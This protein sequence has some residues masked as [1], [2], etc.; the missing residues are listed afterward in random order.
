[1]KK[2]VFLFLLAISAIFNLTNGVYGVEIVYEIDDYEIIID[3]FTENG[4]TGFTVEKTGVNPFVSTVINGTEHYYITGVSKIEEYYIL[5]GYGFTSNSDTE[6]DSLFFILDNAGNVIKKDL[7]DYGF[8]EVIKEVYIIDNIFI[9]YTE[10]TKDIDYNYEFK[11]NYFTT[12]DLNFN[13][14]NS[15]EIGSKIKRIDSNDQ[16][17]LIGYDYYLDYDFAIRSDLTILECDTLLELN[18]GEV[19][20]DAVTIEF[21]NSATLNNSY[22]ENGVFI[23][24][25]GDY[26]LIYNDK[27]Y[28][29]VVE[30]TI[31]GVEDNFIYK[32]SVT[33]FISNGN[34]MLNNDI[35]IS[36]T[37][38]DGPGN[39]E[40]IVTGSNNYVSTLSFTITSNL[41]GIIN[42]N[43]YTDNVSFSFKGEGY[44]NNQFIESPF[45]VN[46][47]G[48]YILKIRGENNYLETYFF[49]IEDDI[50]ETSFI[51][52]VQRVDILVLV[53]VLISGGII[54]KK[55]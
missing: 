49:S 38:I 16:Y 19:F 42:N 14:T 12:Y 13:Y 48:E 32:E 25:P 47:T 15:L 39:Y 33:P 6:Y 7:R 29:F 55:K 34:V 43:I 45:E 27:I 44:L 46:E 24:Y 37:E 4:V 5:Y 35:Y 26:T 3:R 21:L 10:Q 23:N 50:K 54:L 52:F 18:E 40:L 8:M 41:E 17:V 11:S 1:M 30:P 28:N 51:D 22:V 53:V 9:T 20:Y 36:N 2:I 31:T